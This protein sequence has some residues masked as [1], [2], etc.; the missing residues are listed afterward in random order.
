MIAIEAITPDTAKI[1]EDIALSFWFKSKW[2]SRYN[3]EY[4]VIYGPIERKVSQRS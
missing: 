1:I 4:L 3:L 2:E